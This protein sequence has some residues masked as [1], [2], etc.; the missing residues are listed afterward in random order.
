MLMRW[1][2]ARTGQSFGSGERK[3][4]MVCPTR[5]WLFFAVLMLCL[6]PS[7]LSIGPKNWMSARQASRVTLW[8]V[9]T[10]LVN[11]DIRGMP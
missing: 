1:C 6:K 3:T 10:P 5:N 9:V 4:V 8:W 2:I 11:S 7:G